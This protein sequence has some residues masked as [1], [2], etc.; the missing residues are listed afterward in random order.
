M[1]DLLSSDLYGLLDILSS[2]TDQQVRS[3]AIALHQI[4]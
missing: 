3:M 1:G 2:A 4:L